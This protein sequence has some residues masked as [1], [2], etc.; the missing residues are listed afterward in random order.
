MS[1]V[2]CQSQNNGEEDWRRWHLSQSEEYLEENQHIRT[3]SR[4]GWCGGWTSWWEAKKGAVAH[5][6]PVINNSE[7]KFEIKLKTI[8][9]HSHGDPNQ[10]KRSVTFSQDPR[11]HNPRDGCARRTL[12]PLVAFC[13]ARH[14]SDA[15]E[16]AMILRCNTYSG[17]WGTPKVTNCKDSGIII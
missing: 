15:L 14:P 3:N 9:Q 5:F 11:R 8:N 2:Y 17:W 1:L 6:I 16:R 4:K 10:T 7:R 13:N 12:M